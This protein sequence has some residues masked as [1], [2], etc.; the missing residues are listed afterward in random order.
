M[1]QNLDLNTYFSS[2]QYY[3]S[4]L[5]EAQLV[6]GNKKNLSGKSFI[7]VSLTRFCPVGCKF[8]FFKSGPLFRQPTKED[9][10][11]VEG[12]EKFINFAN[13]V[14]L[15]YLLVSGGGEPMME[16]QSVLKILE[17]VISERIVLV[18][19]A[20]WAK[21]IDSADR[22]LSAI[23]EAI[24]R[25]T[26]IS[27]ITVRVSV[28]NEHSISLGLD[29]VINLIKLFSTKYKLLE[30][31]SLQIHSLDGD[32]TLDLLVEKLS[33][34]YKIVRK[35]TIQ[36]RVSDGI[37]VLKIVPKQEIIFFN[38]LEIKVGYAKAFYS[39]LRV[40]LS[41][42][43]LIQKNISVYQQDLLESEDGN[44]SVVLNKLGNPGF[45]FW[46]NYNGNVT[47]WGNQF[48]DNLFNIYIDSPGR[49]INETLKDPA[50]LSFIEKGASFRDAIVSEAN[51]VA[52]IRSKAVNIRDYTGALMFDE[53]RTRLYYTT[54][55]LQEYIK[56]GK[57]SKEK[58]MSLSDD[59]QKLLMAD[60]KALID[61]YN[62]STYT[63][64][65]QTIEAGFN[66]DRVKDILEWIKLGHYKLSNEH[67][68]K[69][70]EFYNTNVEEF[71]RISTLSK[72]KHDL[73]MQVVRMTEHLTHI[74]S[75]V[76]LKNDDDKIIKILA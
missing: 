26:S 70:I 61:A 30:H 21:N 17:N 69:L 15:G 62:A 48:L 35:N 52:V 54:R 27:K 76:L 41:E 29:P 75:L 47:T 45:D 57:I 38:N 44:S 31:L 58:I 59:L 34:S 22:Y 2:P 64:I 12:V 11:T 5:V 18:T 60:K 8:C 36:K 56:E 71:D 19:S 42:F 46:V 43:S 65:E 7:C 23:S 28:D 1:N 32:S 66:K 13:K 6:I 37:S 20:H 25:R 72:L 16:K 73:K 63:I 4:K 68:E 3:R 55:V 10:L 39:N 14:N 50:A 33:D 51:E 24:L 74:K 53:A 9:L 49:V 67:V 40:D